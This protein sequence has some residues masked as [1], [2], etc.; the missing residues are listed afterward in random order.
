MSKSWYDEIKDY[1]FT[2]GQSK[3]GVIDHF[4]QLVWKVSKEVGFGIEMDNVNVYTVANYYPSGIFN[5]LYLENV[6][7][8]VPKKEKSYKELFQCKSAR[9]KEFELVNYLRKIH[10]V[11]PL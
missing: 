8:L 10:H 3:W 6:G 5:N 9:E 2:K 1:Y 7:N 11:S 4:T